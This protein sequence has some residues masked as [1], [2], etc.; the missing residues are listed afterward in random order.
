MVAEIEKEYHKTRPVLV[1]TAS[2][3]DSEIIAQKLKD[4]QIPYVILNARDNTKEALIVQNAGKSGSVTISTN[5]A[6]RGT[7]IKI[8]EKVKKMGGLYVIG[9]ERHESRRIDNQLRGRAGRQGDPGQSRFFISLEDSL[10]KRFAAEKKQKALAKMADDE[11]YNSRF[12]S[13]LLNYAQ[14]KVE[15]LNFDIRKNLMDYDHVLSLQREIIYKQRDAILLQN[16]NQTII[17]N[18]I[19]DF[20]HL[21][22]QTFVKKTNPTMLD[23]VLFCRFLNDKIIYF[24]HYHHQQFVNQSVS[25]G[26]AFLQETLQ[27]TLM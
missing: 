3:S 23:T 9:T 6:G 26:L 20:V 10:F 21:H 15:G 27:K 4:K 5:M 13:K 19:G 17:N 11:Y 14:K 24:P 25:F 8:D 16:D 1:G 18:M 7:D 12:F 2:V 22:A